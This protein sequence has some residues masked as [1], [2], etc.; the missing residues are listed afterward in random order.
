MPLADFRASVA[1]IGAGGSWLNSITAD[2]GI[3]EVVPAMDFRIND[4]E[5]GGAIDFIAGKDF[6]IADAEIHSPICG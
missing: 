3:A 5:M 2:G 6:R 4:A 1:E